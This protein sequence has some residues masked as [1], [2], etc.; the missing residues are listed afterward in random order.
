[1]P[2]GLLLRLHEGQK[3]GLWLTAPVEC[4]PL[5]AKLIVGQGAP[6]CPATG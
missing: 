5:Q 3:S 6:I 4:L 2:S 1:M